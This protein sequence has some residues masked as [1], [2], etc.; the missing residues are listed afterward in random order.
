MIVVWSDPSDWEDEDVLDSWADEDYG[1]DWEDYEDWLK[2]GLTKEIYDAKK[3]E[4][5]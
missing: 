1:D 5:R 3:A 4:G 2:E